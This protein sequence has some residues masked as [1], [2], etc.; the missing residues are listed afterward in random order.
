MKPKIPVP[1]TFNPYKHH[2]GFIQNQIENWKKQNW[3][4]VEQELFCLGENLL[5]FY[6]GKLNVEEICTECIS[7]FSN[8]KITDLFALKTWLDVKEYKKIQLSDSSVWLIK[9]G[10]NPVHFIHIHPAKQS[11]FTQRV[12]A[13]TL[14]TVISL[15]VQQCKIQNRRIDDLGEVNRIRK[16]FL[17]LSPIKSIHPEEGI[18]KLWQIFENSSR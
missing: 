9:P 15:Q 1:I 4:D 3:K 10:L 7:Y 8:K 2:F 13:I 6:T 14:K 5:D 18:Y 17:H 16:N 11:P 12:R